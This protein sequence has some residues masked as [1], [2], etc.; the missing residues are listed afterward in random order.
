MKEILINL[1]KNIPDSLYLR[2]VYLIKK[3]SILHLKNP[4]TFNEKLQWLKVYDHNPLYTTLV[5]KAE[6]KRWIASKIGE[7]FVPKTFGVWDSFDE[8]DFESLPNTFVLKATHDSGTVVFCNDKENFDKE[9][10]NLIFKKALRNNYYWRGREWPYKNVKPRVI[11]EE[12]LDIKSMECAEYKLFCYNG[13][14]NWVMECRGIA[15]RVN[16][17]RTNDGYDRNYNHLPVT[18]TNPNSGKQYQK[19]QQWD[20]LLRIAEILSEGIPEVRVDTYCVNGKIYIGELT[21]FHDG[22]FCDFKPSSWDK[23][24]GIGIDLSR[25]GT[26]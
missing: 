11:A 3:H 25:V 1:A 21:F 14:V 16:G 4:I 23:K 13:V 8:I 9:K 5:D 6:A 19:P 10:A 15:H 20:E 24:F 18:F 12:Y 2:I 22:G 17:G 26:K 7:S